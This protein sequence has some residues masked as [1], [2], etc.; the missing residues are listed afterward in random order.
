MLE[1]AAAF[2][3]IVNE[4]YRFGKIS[5]DDIY[6]QRG[7]DNGLNIGLIAG[8]LCGTFIAKCSAYG[9]ECQRTMR[10]IIKGLHNTNRDTIMNICEQL[11]QS[12]QLE[13]SVAESIDVLRKSLLAIAPR[14]GAS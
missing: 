6:R 14:G 7:F 11:E 1:S 8:K 12:H 3:S 5:G 13:S 4:G 9:P 2:N 10:D